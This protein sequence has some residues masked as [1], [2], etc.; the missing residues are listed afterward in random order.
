MDLIYKELN[1]RSC[2][3]YLVYSRH[4][5]GAIIIDPVIDL[6][7]DYLRCLDEEGLLLIYAI[8]THTH[9][10][11]LS[12]GVVLKEQTGCEYVMHGSSKVACATVRIEEG[13]RHLA[14]IPVFIMHTPGHTKDSISHIFPDRIFVGDLLFLDEGGA[15][16]LDLPGSDA[17][18]H[19][20]SLQR[21]LG[22]PDH[23]TVYPA[24]DYRNRS[25]SSIAVQKM[26]NQYLRP[27]T[28]DEYL[29]FAKYF[30]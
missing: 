19:W 6:V 21:I 4:S 25:A 23:L 9:A 2:R 1:G 28:K 30:Q 24:H 22:L 5:R 13:K 15:G 8:D 20:D 29:A 11:H 14:S 3:T 12:G 17:G 7:N 16:R 26:R 27:R 18:E 10:D